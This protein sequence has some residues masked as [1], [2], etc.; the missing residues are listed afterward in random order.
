MPPNPLFPP[1][2]RSVNPALKVSETLLPAAVAA[3]EIWIELLDRIAVTVVPAG[4]PGP[5]TVML[6]AMPV[7]VDKFEIVVL[8]LAVLPVA[9]TGGGVLGGL[10]MSALAFPCAM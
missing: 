6:T 7:V 8:V 10:A 9:T 2:S 4:M 3:L 5:L 1:K